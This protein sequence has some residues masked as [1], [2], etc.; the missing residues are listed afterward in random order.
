MKAFPVILLLMSSVASVL[1]GCSD[2]LAP[3]SALCDQTASPMS[4]PGTLGKMGTEMHSVTRNAH[5]KI[6]GTQT[7][8]RF[9]FSAIQHADGSFSGEVRNL[10]EGP[11]AKIK[12][13][14]YDLELDGNRAKIC[15]TTANGGERVGAT[16]FEPAT[17][18]SQSRRSSRAELRPENNRIT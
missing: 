4:S 13:R 16:G 5:W 1:S 17:S 12:G 18:C 3:V 15:F 10:D 11:Q 6:A 14:V 8:V 7:Q 9:S 2:S